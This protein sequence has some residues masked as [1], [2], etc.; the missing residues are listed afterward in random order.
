MVF[1]DEIAQL[2]YVKNEDVRESIRSTLTILRQFGAECQ[3]WFHGTF[4]YHIVGIET[5][6]DAIYVG[7]D[8]IKLSMDCN[9]LLFDDIS[10]EEVHHYKD[11]SV[12]ILFSPD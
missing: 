7:R 12:D 11:Q 2:E 8:Y 4:D 6:I 10:F 3:F 5:P 9:D 1:D